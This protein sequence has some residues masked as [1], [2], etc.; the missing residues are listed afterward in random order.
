MECQAHYIQV[1]LASELY[2]Y[3]GK[4][5]EAVDQHIQILQNIY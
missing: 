4:D 3:T 2:H 5:R 1:L